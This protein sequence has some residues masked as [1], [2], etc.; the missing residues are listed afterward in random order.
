MKKQGGT[1]RA[2]LL[3][4]C[5]AT[6]AAF[7][8]QFATVHFLFGGNWTGL[9]YCGD[10]DTPMPPELDGEQI[11][12]FHGVTGHDGRYY[13]LVAHDPLFKR[14]FARYLDRPALRY[15]RI[16]VPGLAA[17][18]S[19]GH[20]NWVD[21][22]FFAEILVF[23]FLGTFWLASWSVSHGHSVYWGFLFCAT[24]ATLTSVPITLIDVSLAALTAGFV[25]YVEQKSPVKLF[26][27]LACAV[28]ARE[29]GLLLLIGWCGWLVFQRHFLLAIKY[30]AAALPSACW[31][32][33]V[34]LHSKPTGPVWLSPIPLY[35]FLQA[36]IH[37]FKY[38][39][40]LMNRV[41][42][43]LDRMALIGML[44]ALVYVF[45]DALRP[46]RRD[47]KTFAALAFAVF[48]LFLAGGDVWPEATAFSRT[49]TPLLLMLALS[50]ILSRNWWKLSPLV[51][52]APRIGLIYVTAVGR[53]VSAITHR[54]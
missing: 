6:T 48:A 33:F 4:A 8:W 29:T 20:S 26:A 27:V 52:M 25:L 44:V 18:L 17:L 5:L 3:I 47:Y 22:V 12:R 42:V 40:G 15:R 21:P 53:L 13:H 19:F 2:R 36:F 54:P 7:C 14:N 37:P 35:G 23:V 1:L 50:G 43:P 39:A 34:N 24:P 9:F 46:T 32:I 51:L 49:F 28:L 41:L 30:A 38:P 10:V 16:L 11:Y 45:W 31:D